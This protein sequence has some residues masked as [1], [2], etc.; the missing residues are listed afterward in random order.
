MCGR[1]GTNNPAVNP[2]TDY[3]GHFE[4][5]RSKLTAK[6]SVKL[7]ITSVIMSTFGQPRFLTPT[8]KN[9]FTSYKLHEPW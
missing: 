7:N 3:S 9:R 4:Q 5:S 1:Q 8:D 6:L 2:A